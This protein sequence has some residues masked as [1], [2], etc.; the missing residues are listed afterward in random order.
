[1]PSP[2]IASASPPQFNVA[3]CLRFA[4]VTSSENIKQKLG[5]VATHER[6]RKKPL[7]VVDW[8]VISGAVSA[9]D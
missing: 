6:S 1:M 9:W 8:L 5:N 2:P 3:S 4:I 7:V